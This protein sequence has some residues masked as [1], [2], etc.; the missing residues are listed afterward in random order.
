M[1][2]AVRAVGKGME[3]EGGRE[4]EPVNE[5]ERE[6]EKERETHTRGIGEMNNIELMVK[7]N[8]KFAM[9]EPN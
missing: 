3:R 5:R 8:N 9:L 6:R 2:V 1:A 4:K 7:G